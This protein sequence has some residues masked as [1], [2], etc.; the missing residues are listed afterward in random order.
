MSSSQV[1]GHTD[2]DLTTFFNKINNRSAG[3]AI[4]DACLKAFKDLEKDETKVN[5]SAVSKVFV[6]AAKSKNLG[7]RTSAAAIST[8]L[9]G[10][11]MFAHMNRADRW[12]IISAMGIKER[13]KQ[14]VLE[15]PR[16]FENL[17][18]Y[19]LSQHG[20]QE[21]LFNGAIKSLSSGESKFDRKPID[22][23]VNKYNEDL[24]SE[25]KTHPKSRMM[26]NLISENLKDR[27]VEMV[28]KEWNKV[29][30][31]AAG[32][33]DREDLLASQDPF[34]HPEELPIQDKSLTDLASSHEEKTKPTK[35]YT[36]LQRFFSEEKELKNMN[37]IVED[38]SLG[39]RKDVEGLSAPQIIEATR[40][41]ITMFKRGAPNTKE[42]GDRLAFLFEYI[43]DNQNALENAVGIQKGTLLPFLQDSKWWQY[44]PIDIRG[45]LR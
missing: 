40:R 32:R 16:I 2:V 45:I 33:S 42:M 12:N 9:A 5:M 41:M 30:H 29:A 18:T 34:A 20:M 1:Q 35:I 44:V 43:K 21:A 17:A 25:S 27:F 3:G 39:R 31:E 4:V 19:G 23:A 6:E 8:K 26:A 11:E 14:V 7:L 37:A 38:I 24:R 22:A 36:N 10:S 13:F 28:Q 15:L